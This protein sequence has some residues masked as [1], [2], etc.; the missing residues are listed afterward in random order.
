MY[1]P[2]AIDVR[3]VCESVVVLLPNLDEDVNVDVYVVV[4][5]EVPQTLFL[6]E[7][8]V[9]RILMNLL[10]NALKFTRNGYIKLS[11]NMSEKNL[12]ANIEDTGC[13]L[14]PAFIP[15][16]WTPFK[17]GEVRG[18]ARGTGLGLSIIKQLVQRMEGRIEVE[19]NYEHLEDIGPDRSGTR[20]TVTLPV[21]TARRRS[22]PA[23]SPK[24]ESRQPKIAILWKG[25]PTRAI[26]GLQGSWELF[27]FEV[28]LV[29]HVNDLHA[30]DWKYVWGELEFFSENKGQFFTLL[31]SHKK[32]LVL[33]PY[34][35][36]NSMEGLPGIT[37]APNFVMLHKPLIWHTFERRITNQVNA[38][39]QALRFAES[40][41][42]LN[43]ESADL[44]EPSYFDF[45]PR[46]RTTVLLVEDNPINQRLGKK[47]LLSLG[48]NVITSMDGQDAIDTLLR[49][50]PPSSA[51]PTPSHSIW[52]SNPPT[53][54]SNGSNGGGKTPPQSLPAIDII[55]MDQSMPRKDGITATRE[56]RNMEALGRLTGRKPIIAVTA[57]VNSEA[58]AFFREAGADEFLA[59]PLALQKLK[60][61]LEGQLVTSSQ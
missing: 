13:G 29:S 52:R 18:S 60:E 45:K 41:E 46:R 14:D 51:V 35:A 31:Q 33:V 50:N 40:V 20:F 4:S 37:S 43:E 22:V 17:Q 47:M 9:H 34:D 8:W 15:E 44:T 49:H 3:S 7:T 56:I 53:P 55:L 19:S 30:D 38:P 6:D 58:Q 12:V 42:V 59:K 5:P 1:R 10:S 23:T 2:S 54:M 61:A 57:V 27:G 21:Q 26:E 16:M 28:T 25:T 24:L 11:L 48:Y 32:W 39:S 36:H